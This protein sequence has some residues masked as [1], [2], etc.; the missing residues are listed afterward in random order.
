MAI[1]LLA[2]YPTK[3]GPVVP[4]VWPYGEPRNIT[5]PGDGTGTPWEAALVKDIC[6]FQQALVTAAS[7]VPSGTPEQVGGSEYLQAIVELAS[8][9][10]FNYDESGVA[11]TYVGDARTGLEGPASYFTDMV[12]KFTP[13]NTNTGAS[14]I[15]VAGLGIK[16]IFSGGGALVGGELVA[17]RQY[18]LIYN[19]TEFEI[20]LSTV[21]TPVLLASRS[22]NGVTSVDFTTEITSAFRRYRVEFYDLEPV[23]LTPNTFAAR[24]SQA[25]TFITTGY[26]T[27]GTAVG[28]NYELSAAATT[29]RS[30]NLAFGWFELIIG[31]GVAIKEQGASDVQVNTGSFGGTRQ[32]RG[33]HSRNDLIISDGLRLLFTTGN[34]AQGKFK[35]F[36]IPD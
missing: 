14:T 31:D 36:G 35:L 24:I 32:L 5:A 34:I 20:D 29:F 8:G 9:R 7:I 6:G 13:G 23:T 28:A 3:V 30:D 19:G 15:N 27:N 11:N 10:A 17:G 22:V 4:D 2:Q 26:H 1:N 12:V 16:N 18:T 25:S 21:A 33:E